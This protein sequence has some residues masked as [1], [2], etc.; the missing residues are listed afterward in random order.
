[1]VTVARHFASFQLSPRL[2]RAIFERRK[3]PAALLLTQILWKSMQTQFNL[4]LSPDQL[5]SLLLQLPNREKVHLAAR[6]RQEVGTDEW[7]KWSALLPDLPS[8]SMDEIVGQ[9]NAVR[10]LRYES[11]S[12]N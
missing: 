6:L 1:M 11:R 3:P 8:I 5:W 7:E 2:S 12:S 10:Q 4:T 9:V